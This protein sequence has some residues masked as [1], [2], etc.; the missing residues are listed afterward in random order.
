M[1]HHDV[2]GDFGTPAQGAPRATYKLTFESG[3]VTFQWSGLACGS[4]EAELRARVDLAYKNPGRFDGPK[5][6]L[7]TCVS[8]D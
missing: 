5:A 1:S 4:V 6:Q 2:P 7:L 8:V 3:G